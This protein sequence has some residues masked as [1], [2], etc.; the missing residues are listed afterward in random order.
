MSRGALKVF[1]EAN[2]DFIS[3]EFAE[4]I[5]DFV[6]PGLGNWGR[7]AS[8][9]GSLASKRTTQS[10]PQLY[11]SQSN[12]HREELC[13]RS[14]LN[15]SS[16]A[17]LIKPCWL[18]S[19]VHFLLIPRPCG[20]S[21]GPFPFLTNPPMLIEYSFCPSHKSTLAQRR[22]PMSRKTPRRK[23]AHQGQYWRTDRCR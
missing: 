23:K 16:S 21:G 6:T 5:R 14:C 4:R 8:T 10:P 22:F 11:K 18:L 3:P 19:M 2:S 15:A 12:I 17:V 13:V 20:K 7:Q 1:S 9:T